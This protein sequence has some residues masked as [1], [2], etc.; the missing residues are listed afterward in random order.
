MNLRRGQRELP[1]APFGSPPLQLRHEVAPLELDLALGHVDTGN[2]VARANGGDFP[3]V[4]A[5]LP[6]NCLLVHG[7][8]VLA[9]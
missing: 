5:V 4:E 1:L 9:D 7:L 2:T 6:A 3:G 8:Q